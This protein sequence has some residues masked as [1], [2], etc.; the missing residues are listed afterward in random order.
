MNGYINAGTNIKSHWNF[1]ANVHYHSNNLS[2]SENYPSSTTVSCKF[3]NL[4]LIYLF[5]KNA[6]A[7]TFDQYIFGNNL[8][9]RGE[10]Y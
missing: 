7:C 6:Y 4:H 1:I 2:Y 5:P 3:P 10:H 8:H 9:V